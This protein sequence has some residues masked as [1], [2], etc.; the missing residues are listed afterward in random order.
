MKR[1]HYV[2]QDQETQER[3]DGAYSL[4]TLRSDACQPVIKININ[5]VPVE[6]EL[7]TGAAYTV[8]T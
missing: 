8:I 3:E 5:G 6:M 2:K 7:D 1:T 4:F